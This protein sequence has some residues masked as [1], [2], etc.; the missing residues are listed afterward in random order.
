MWG[1]TSGAQCWAMFTNY[2][3]SK[4]LVSEHQRDL[5]RSAARARAARAVRRIRRPTTE[6][7]P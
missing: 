2:E 7:R 1:G 5:E 6:Q 4:V 3:I